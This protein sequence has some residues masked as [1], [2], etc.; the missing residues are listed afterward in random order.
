MVQNY[1]I[2]KTL[3]KIMTEWVYKGEPFQGP[4]DIKEQYGFVYRITHIPTGKFYIGAKFFWKPKYNV[5]KGKKKKSW[6]ESD[7][8]DYWSSSEKLNADVIEFGK[9]NFTREIIE[10]VKFRGMV[11]YVES[12]LIFALECLERDDSYNSIIG[13]KIHRR[14]VRR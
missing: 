9:E 3:K 8:R 10:I 2:Q 14:C 7:W 6:V 1:L 13:C 12:K 11:K 4:T 5:V